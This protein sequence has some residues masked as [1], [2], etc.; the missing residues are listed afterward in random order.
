MA[1]QPTLAVLGEAQIIGTF[2][3][4]FLTADQGDSWLDARLLMGTGR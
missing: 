2:N 1:L 3:L 4:H